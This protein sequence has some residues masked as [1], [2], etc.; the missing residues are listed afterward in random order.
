MYTHGRAAFVVGSDIDM[1]H[2]LASAMHT[3]PCTHTLDHLHTCTSSHP[4]T[5]TLIPHMIKS[6]HTSNPSHPNFTYATPHILTFTH[7]PPHVLTFTHVPSHVLTFTH[8]PPHI[9]TFT[10]APSTPHT[11]TITLD[12]PLQFDHMVHRFLDPSDISSAPHSSR[13]WGDGG[14][15]APEVGLLTHNIVIQGE[16]IHTQSHSQTTLVNVYI[17]HH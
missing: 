1:A 15:L 2:V 16:E 9:L 17:L 7:A 5:H 6:L 10:H 13:W 8:A 3:Y 12:T 4:H 14:S 11:G